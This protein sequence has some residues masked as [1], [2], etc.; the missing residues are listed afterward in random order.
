MNKREIDWSCKHD[1]LIKNPDGTL[2]PMD[3]PFYESRELVKDVY[4]IL[5]SGDYHYV[6]KGRTKGVAI[7]TG[8]GAGNTREYLEGLI[9]LP[10]PDVIN[11]HHH[12]DHTANNGYFERALMHKNAISCATEPFNSFL[13]ID[14][15]TDYKREIVTEGD[16]Y[17]LDD[18]KLEI[19]EI[20]DHSDNG[21]AILD[22]ADRVLFTGDEFMRQGKTLRRASV[23]EFQAYTKKLLDRKA[24]YD[25]VLAGAGVFDVKFLQAF[26][27]CAT[28][29]LEGNMG[30][31]THFKHPNFPM[32]Y[33][34]DGRVI[35]DRIL[36]RPGDGGAGKDI[37]GERI[38]RRV[39]YAGTSITFYEDE[40]K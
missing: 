20:P 30:E 10:V 34:P 24:D 7:D 23:K 17:E 25:L 33:A 27:E 26:Y 36:P 39:E 13:G 5:S 4:Q 16:V 19:F 32:E 22:A 28:Y 3:Q 6:I 12:F 21:I 1:V 15:I 14:F 9:G 35:Y 18:K 8:Y 37:S 40:F 29:I 2:L 38:Q 31:V 11:T